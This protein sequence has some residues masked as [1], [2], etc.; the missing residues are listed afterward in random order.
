[1]TGSPYAFMHLQKLKLIHTNKL[2]SLNYTSCYVSYLPGPREILFA[3]C[4]LSPG[5]CV[6]QTA[7]T[8][9]GGDRKTPGV[10]AIVYQGQLQSWSP[11]EA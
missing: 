1:M 10:S 7:A 6:K 11:G 5:I 4:G 3:G 8:A 9:E 2:V